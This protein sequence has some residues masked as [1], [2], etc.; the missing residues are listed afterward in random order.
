MKYIAIRIKMLKEEEAKGIKDKGVNL[1]KVGLVL[2]TVI[3][4][5]TVYIISEAIIE[6]L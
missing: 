1:R 5:L 3:T 2:I 4:T 6:K